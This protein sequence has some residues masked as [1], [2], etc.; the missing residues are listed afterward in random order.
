MKKKVIV[1]PEMS[2]ASLSGYV[3]VPLVASHMAVNRILPLVVEGGSSGVGLGFV[4]H[5]FAKHPVLAWSTYTALIG[6]AMGHIVW[7]VVR[8]RGWMPS[9]MERERK[10]RWWVVNGAVAGVTALWMAGGLG[11]VA[12]GGAEG[13]WVGRG[14]D[15]LYAW[16]PFLG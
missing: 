14:Y 15:D 8:W 9:G 5:G 2:W 6:T 16:I 4:S 3:F 7:G 13:G 11:V 10:R 1:W 12:R